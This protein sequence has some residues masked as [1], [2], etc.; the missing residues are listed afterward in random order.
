MAPS[1]SNLGDMALQQQ[2]D[3]RKRVAKACDRC[4]LKK[5]KVSPYHNLAL[6]T[7]AYSHTVRRQCTM[8]QMSK[9]E[10]RLPIWRAE[11]EYGAK[12][13]ARLRRIP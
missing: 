7:P 10:R 8:H 3:G 11:E 5:V 13:S 12:D 6:T 4:R 2:D 1:Y 9:R